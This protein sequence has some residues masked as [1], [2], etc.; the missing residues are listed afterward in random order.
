MSAVCQLLLHGNRL[1]DFAALRPL[2]VLLRL[3][4]LT[5]HGNP[6]NLEAAPIAESNAAERPYRQ[7]V[8]EPAFSNY[9]RHCK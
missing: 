5:L 6:L 9:H 7:K 8:P 1:P 2:V 3:Q 4:Q